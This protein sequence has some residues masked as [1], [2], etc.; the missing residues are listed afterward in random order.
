MVNELK[1]IKKVK[2][3]WDIDGTLLR[4]N[5]AAALPFAKAVSEYAG[6]EVI[7][8]RKKLS[9]FT[10]YEIAISLLG[11][12]GITTSLKDITLILKSY[13]EKLPAALDNGEVKKIG[14]VEKVLETV[15]KIPEIELAIGTGNFLPGAKIKLNHVGLMNYFD[16]NNLF[17]SSEN[18]WSRDLIIN[19]AKNSLTSNQIGIVIGDSPKDILSAKA[20]GLK[21]IAVTTGSHSHTELSEYKPDL[22]LQEDWQVEDLIFGINIL[23]QTL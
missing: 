20:S 8:D 9:G 15:L 19:N 2:L 23:V 10:D 11:S 14:H 1:L 18:Y 5:G 17:C 6:V 22:I 7:I 13:V 12:I 3:F 4:T 21:N 16:N